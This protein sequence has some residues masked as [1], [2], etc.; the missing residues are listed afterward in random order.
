M[1]LPKP[2]EKIDTSEIGSGATVDDQVAN[3]VQ[4]SPAAQA[5]STAVDQ[6]AQDTA[7]TF[8]TGSTLTPA[9]KLLA[10]AALPDVA[11]MAQTQSNPKLQEFVEQFAERTAQST[12]LEA[13]LMG[14]QKAVVRKGQRSAMQ[15]NEMPARFHAS[16]SY[17]PHIPIRS[18]PPPTTTDHHAETCT[19][20]DGKGLVEAV[21]ARCLYI[22]LAQGAQYNLTKVAINVTYPVAIVGDPFRRPMLDGRKCVHTQT[23]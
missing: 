4:A 21:K 3:A 22:K 7:L 15:C 8:N 2:V 23:Q 9:S 13:A 17:N 1:I 16:G 10:G 14:F 12:Q 19:P 6:A 11:A 5:A 18:L 20:A